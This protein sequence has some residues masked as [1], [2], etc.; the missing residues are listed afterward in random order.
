MAETPGE[1]HPNCIECGLHEK[2]R[3]PFLDGAGPEDAQFLVV[4]KCPG[5][6]EDFNGEV[7]IG[8]S[9]D[10]LKTDL[11]RGG[12][13]VSDCRFTNAGRCRPSS[14][15]FPGLGTVKLCRPFLFAEVERIRPRA[16][17]A[18]GNE[19]LYAFSGKVGV[20][21]K[22]QTTF[23]YALE[24][25]TKIPVMVALHP[26]AVLHQ[27]NKRKGFQADMQRFA[28]FV[29][30]DGEPQED[31]PF[32]MCSSGALDPARE[33]F[34]AKIRRLRAVSARGQTTVGFDCETDTRYPFLHREDFLVRCMAVSDGITALVLQIDRTDGR[35]NESDDPALS[36][37]LDLLVDPTIRLAAH[38][39]KYDMHVIELRFGRRVR[40][41]VADTLLQHA[42][43]SPH[44]GGHDLDTVAPEIL[45]VAR[46]HGAVDKLVGDGKDRAKWRAVSFDELARRCAHD[47]CYTA[48]LAVKLGSQI[49]RSGT[50]DAREWFRSTTLLLDPPRLSGLFRDLVMPGMRALYD[51]E[52]TGIA[53]DPEKLAVL[54]TDLER[55]QEDLRGEIRSLPVVAARQRRVLLDGM[56][57][58]AERSVEKKRKPTAKQ[59]AAVKGDAEFNPGADRQIADVLFDAQYYAQGAVEQTAGGKAS[60]NEVSLHAVAASCAVVSGIPHAQEIQQ[61]ISLVLGY[62]E[63]ANLKSSFVTRLRRFRCPDGRIHAT[64]NLGRARTGRLSISDP[65]LQNIPVRNERYAKKIRDAFVASPGMTLVEPD[66][67]Q[68]ELRVLA[69]YS[70]DEEM[71]A[72]F[73]EGRDLHEETAKTIFGVE[74][75]TTEQRRE[76]K[77][78]NFGVIFLESEYGLARQIGSSDQQAASFIS[79][80]YSRFVGVHEWQERVQHYVMRRGRVYTMFGRSRLLENARIRPRDRKERSLLGEALRQAVNTPIQGTAA[81]VCLVSL[82]RLSAIVPTLPFKTRILLTV[83]DSILFEVEEG[84]EEDLCRIVGPVMIAE[85]MKWIG[86]QMEGVPIVVDFK[87]GSTRW[88]S[89][90]ERVVA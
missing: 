23:E 41:L 19:A 17:L 20:E 72:V 49:A 13:A 85:P 62:R 53:I 60:V 38:N 87:M 86:P 6:R 83:H 48:R 12:I 81:D 16:I 24:D 7:F 2:C 80:F 29:S 55:R 51:M 11:R 37:L 76:G 44:E 63:A 46:W 67:S 14:D 73:R 75:P 26:A 10:I 8:P 65:G 5:G 54:E 66:Y 36:A 52:R 33:A 42:I 68:I 74:A 32:E 77:S 25:G 28:E 82:I 30:G 3:S 58:I 64:V 45:G 78:V 34:A 90:T 47:A 56:N 4:G 27:R 21:K 40:G 35:V 79:A 31:I 15:K 9:G 69:A 84:R 43:L 18:L 39:A 22:R 61:F 89:L 88:G 1:A 59:I 50:R 71:L 57:R 70:R